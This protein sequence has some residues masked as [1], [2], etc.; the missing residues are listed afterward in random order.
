M[1][2]GFL[3]VFCLF[4]SF[5][6]KPIQFVENL[7]FSRGNVV[8]GGKMESTVRDDGLFYYYYTHACVINTFLK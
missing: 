7:I 2:A 1:I 8:R 4:F 6:R 3:A 5:P